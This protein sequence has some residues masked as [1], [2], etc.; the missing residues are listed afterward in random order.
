LIGAGL[1]LTPLTPFIRI[2]AKVL[3]LFL[4]PFLL[5]R[6]GFFEMAEIKILKG[7]FKAWKN[8]RHLRNNIERL[9]S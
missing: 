7:I 5:V 6:V 8:P 3:I 9:I 4:Y 2:P 1:L